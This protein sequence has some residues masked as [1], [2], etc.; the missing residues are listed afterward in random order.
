MPEVMLRLAFLFF[1][2]A[3]A[4][5]FESR[6]SL[7]RE[8][9]QKNSCQYTVNRGRPEPRD[10][11]F[12][13][14][15]WKKVVS[16]H[17]EQDFLQCR[18]LC[19]A[20]PQCVAF[21]RRASDDV[22]YLGMSLKSLKHADD[23]P[24]KLLEVPND[25]VVGDCWLLE[26]GKLAKYKLIEKIW[27]RITSKGKYNYPF[28]T[29]HYEQKTSFYQSLAN[30]KVTFEKRDC[31]CEYR[32]LGLVLPSG[33]WPDSSSIASNV[34]ASNASHP[35]QIL[36][37][38]EGEYRYIRREYPKVGFETVYQ[39]TDGEKFIYL[40]PGDKNKD[41]TLT[42]DWYCF[43]KDE[44]VFLKEKAKQASKWKAVKSVLGGGPLIND[45]TEC[46]GQ[47]LPRQG[48]AALLPIDLPLAKETKEGGERVASSYPRM[49][50]MVLGVPPNKNGNS[51]YKVEGVELA[52][53]QA[54]FSCAAGKKES[55]VLKKD[56]YLKTSQCML[57]VD[58]SRIK[59]VH[60]MNKKGFTQKAMVKM[61]AGTMRG[62][63]SGFF[64]HS[65]RSYTSI[66]WRALALWE[67]LEK[68][69]ALIN[70]IQDGVSSNNQTMGQGEKYA[71]AELMVD[72]I[73]SAG[74][75]MPK[76]SQTLAMKPDVV[77]DDFVRSALKST[78]TENPAKSLDAVR[79]YVASKLEE[80]IQNEERTNSGDVIANIDDHLDLDITLATGSVAQVLRAWVKPDASPMVRNLCDKDHPTCA[81]VL[82]VVFDENEKKYEDDWEAIQFLGND[83]LKTI[84]DSLEGG[85]IAKMALSAQLNE[86]EMEM[87]RHGVS[88]GYD[89]WQ[90]VRQ[91]LGAVMDE[92]DLRI[93]DLNAQA[94]RTAV[95]SFDQDVKLKKELGIDSITF[96]VPKVL[97]TKS[98][99][100]MLQSFAKGDTLTSYHASISG[101]ADKLKDWRRNIYPSIM[102]LY[103][104][105]M[106]E[107][108]FFQG[109]PH[110]GNWYWEAESK[111][112]TLIDWGLA[113]DFSGGLARA[114]QLYLDA[115]GNPPKKGENE[116]YTQEDV[117][118]AIAE[119]KCGI[120]KF[121]KNMADF[122]RKE[123]LCNGFSVEDSST[124]KNK[125]GPM[126]LVP[127]PSATIILDGTEH[128]LHSKYFARNLSLEE[129]FF[130]DAFFGTPS[131]GV[132]SRKPF[133][134]Q[135]R[136]NPTCLEEDECGH[137]WEFAQIDGEGAKTFRPV[138]ICNSPECVDIFD[139][140]HVTNEEI[141]KK[142]CK[143]VECIKR[144][145]K[146]TSRVPTE[147]DS[148][149]VSPIKLPQCKQ[150]PSREKAY[151]DGAASLGFSTENM[152]P[153]V[154]S[155]FAALHTNDLL[156]LKARQENIQMNDPKEPGTSIPDYS[157]VMLRSLA[158]FLGMIQD[159]VAENQPPFVSMPITEYI[160]D[161]A[162]DEMFTYWHIFAKRFLK[163]AENECKM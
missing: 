129:A 133:V 88:A 61:I 96:D 6:L 14:T 52:D 114:G 155:L 120:A 46:L 4:A 11:H 29:L 116:V 108:G 48:D 60:W 19:D 33:V 136:R 132:G 93:E 138:K 22:G 150:L 36:K 147:I 5:R 39:R 109:D 82:K 59:W 117:D 159:M 81:V 141:C 77:K 110:P 156:D 140:E 3:G 161:T 12:R 118:A 35:N 146:I 10:G 32:Y 89:T 115:D 154:L 151:A 24:T 41:G 157:A 144:C 130:G 112:L 135:R 87:A 51:T 98:R 152:N 85:G 28:E 40:C 25:V 17:K 9:R 73:K 21:V 149:K 72:E 104:Y 90:A 158:V 123:L 38:C 163:N 74:G 31:Q 105:L 42:R 126:V 71:C 20:L 70:Y 55:E 107:R 83:L 162:P 131:F 23:D 26:T 69:I 47:K 66:I 134:L 65:G 139:D 67:K 15:H 76:V 142:T 54:F 128:Q 7:D 86:E 160:I 75:I 44:P 63:F 16:Y 99:Y 137:G 13:R 43:D 127:S 148:L 49:P 153:V 106:V 121:Y 64:G 53:G 50:V 101:Q 111:T 57:S 18:A 30:E 145:Q 1:V 125:L 91:G 78:Q 124:K 92:F 103:G 80:A 34:D 45:L 2:L 27:S 122:R 37:D 119:H 97:M 84:H 58:H 95:L 8:D 56:F 68:A 100:I 143:N 94:G 79:S 113:D 62:F 102:G